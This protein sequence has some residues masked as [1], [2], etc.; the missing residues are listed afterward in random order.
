M[1]KYKNW[2]ASVKLEIALAALKSEMTLNEVCQHY[3]VSS[4]QVNAWGRV[5]VPFFL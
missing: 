1:A 4:S 3:D 5:S 2:S